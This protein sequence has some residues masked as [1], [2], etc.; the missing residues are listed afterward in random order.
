MENSLA[1]SQ[2]SNF[3]I[4]FSRIFSNEQLFTMLNILIEFKKGEIE[5][6]LNQQRLYIS[7]VGFNRKI[8]EQEI[9]HTSNDLRFT[10]FTKPK[11]KLT[12]T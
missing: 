9:T 1:C 4:I 2:H 12:A 5:N 8:I 7:Q 6:K 11:I 10:F 3:F